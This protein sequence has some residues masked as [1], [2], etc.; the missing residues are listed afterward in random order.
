MLAI[1]TVSLLGGVVLGMKF[2][3]RS[4]IPA[5]LAAAAL[6]AGLGVADGASVGETALNLGAMAVALQIGYLSGAIWQHAVPA[7]RPTRPARTDTRRVA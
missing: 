2:R 4:A 3:V 1:A 6:V 7:P 5:V